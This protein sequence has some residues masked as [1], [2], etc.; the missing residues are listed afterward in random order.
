MISVFGRFNVRSLYVPWMF[1]ALWVLIG[2]S[3]FKVIPGILA[4]Y[5][6]SVMDGSSHRLHAPP[7]LAR[8]CA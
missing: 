7:F 6:Y 5:I 3:A 1:C 2:G 8:I 4:G